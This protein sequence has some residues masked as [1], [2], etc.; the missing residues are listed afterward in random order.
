MTDE[1]GLPNLWTRRFGVTR[2]ATT[3]ATFRDLHWAGHRA[4][5]AG[6]VYPIVATHGAR[7]L[8]TCWVLWQFVQPFLNWTTKLCRTP[9][10]YDGLVSGDH[11]WRLALWARPAIAPIAH[12]SKLLSHLLVLAG[13][14][15]PIQLATTYD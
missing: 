1:P 3:L 14:F 7:S 9:H 8:Q 2:Q 4:D 6:N 15:H 10:N 5:T 11:Q 12:A 13:P